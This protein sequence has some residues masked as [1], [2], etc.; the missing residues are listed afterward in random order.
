MNADE[1]KALAKRAWDAYDRC[2]FEAFAQCVTEDWI[3]YSDDDRSG[4]TEMRE[5]IGRQREGLSDKRTEFLVELA[6]GDLVAQ[7]TLTTGRHTGKYVDLAPTG[8]TYRMYQ[9]NIHRVVGQRIAE[10]WIAIGE[11]GGP[12]DQL[13]SSSP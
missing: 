5:L 8:K 4:L 10:T 2:D 9:I 12:Y 11:A 3:E 1:M 6:E 7:L 13:R